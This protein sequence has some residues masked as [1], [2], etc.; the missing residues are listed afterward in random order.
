MSDGNFIRF[1]GK[2]LSAQPANWPV[3]DKFVYNWCNGIFCG[4]GTRNFS[5][6]FSLI[7]LIFFSHSTYH[8]LGHATSRINNSDDICGNTLWWQGS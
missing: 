7:G 3:I 2:G 1:W 6:N 4:G 8:A 5:V